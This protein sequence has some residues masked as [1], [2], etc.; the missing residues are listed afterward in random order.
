MRAVMQLSRVGGAASGLRSTTMRSRAFHT[1][2]EHGGWFRW[3]SSRAYSSQS[4]QSKDA[5]DVRAAATFFFDTKA[6]CKSK[7][8]SLT[9]GINEDPKSCGEDSFFVSR[10]IVG[11][12][13]GV[14]GW[15]ENGVDPGEIS[16]SLMR[17]S[18]EFIKDQQQQDPHADILPQDVLAAAFDQTQRDDSVE[19]GS[20]TACIVKIKASVDGKPVLQYSN[21]GD[22]GFAVIRDGQVVFRSEFQCYGRA[23]YQLAKIPPRFRCY[24]AIENQ[25]S[26]A[27]SGEIEVQVGD[28]IVLATDGVWDNFAADLRDVPRFSPPVLSWR[29]HWHPEIT[30]LLD[31][32]EQDATDPAANII[33]AA[34][35]HNLKPDDITVIVARI[36]EHPTSAK[37]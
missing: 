21:L 37:L 4:G 36:V 35:R 30:S 20:T 2:H 5:N 33:K 34:V 26:D 13:D 25:P 9:T 11:V 3:R 28:I 18:I 29:R 15:N 22:S 7:R 8:C 19:A 14:G 16:R 17:Y 23:P 1:S 32:L 27:D 12:A 10:S 6:A 31:V 24:G